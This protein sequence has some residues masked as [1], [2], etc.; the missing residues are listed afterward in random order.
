V[1]RVVGRICG[2]IAIVVGTIAATLEIFDFWQRRTV[3]PAGQAESR[4]EDA[5]TTSHLARERWADI[6]TGGVGA[7][8]LQGVSPAE[9]PQSP[10]AAAERLINVHAVAGG[11]GPAVAIALDGDSPDVELV[12]AALAQE[13]ASARQRLVLGLFKPAF[14]ERGF[15]RAVL[16][17]DGE[18][19][20][21]S[22]ALTL[23]DRVVI[24]RVD[25]TCRETGQLD[26]DLHTCEIRLRFKTVDRRGEILTA[27]HYAAAGA[28]FSEDSARDRAIAVLVEQHGE[29]VITVP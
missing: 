21:E 15:L 29:R 14:R 28:G 4:A 1:W 17:G 20:A 25:R 26:S 10:S 11:D 24:G 13:L 3:A 18:V 12:E 16:D 27:G 2:G 8:D 9:P 23:V 22:G 5:E 6:E 7:S 19:L